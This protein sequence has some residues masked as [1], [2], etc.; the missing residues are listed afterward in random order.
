M[1]YLDM[2]TWPRRDHFKIFGAYD[3]PHFGMCA[4]VDLTKFYP[5]VKERGHSINMAIVYLLS[6]AANAIPEFRYRIRKGQVVEHEIV[7]PAT[8]ILVDEDVFGFAFFDY[9]EDF[10]EFA[11]RAEEKIARYQEQ[12]TLEDEPGRDDFL[13][14]TAIP[15]VS[16]TSFTHPMHLHPADSVPRFAWG[17]FFKDGESLKMPLDVYAHHGL[18]DGIHVG[19]FFAEV[20]DYLRDPNMVLG[21]S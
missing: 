16:F 13:F 6:R 9:I 20:E 4:N 12:P 10:P 11:A 21:E 3:H 2:Q 19:R 14:M 7:H 8:T 15:W 17:R 1:R 5:A 18:M